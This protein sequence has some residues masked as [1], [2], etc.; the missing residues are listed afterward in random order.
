[1]KKITCLFICFLLCFSCFP[2]AFAEKASTWEAEF[3]RIMQKTPLTKST[4]FVL[5]DVDADNVPELIAGNSQT[6]SLY[7]FSNNSLVRT[8]EV[9]DIHIDY[10]AQLK[11]VQKGNAS[12]EFVGQVV[13]SDRITSYKMRFIDGVPQLKTI[14]TENQDAT[15]SFYGDNDTS[16]IVPD[17]TA[18]VIDYFSKYSLTPST[19]CVLSREEARSFGSILNAATS[20]CARYN[21]LASLSDDTADFSADERNA[22]KDAVGKG[23]F[24]FFDKIS[25]LSSADIFV[26]FYVSTP[27]NDGN[28]LL[29]YAKQFALLTKTE[30]GFSTSST[31]TH[32]NK[33]DITHL[34]SLISAEN[35]VSNISFDYKRTSAF[36]GIDDYVNYLSSTLSAASEDANENGKYAISEYIEHA[37]TRSSR[38]EIKAKN[39]TISLN[40]YSVS[41][42]AEN[43]VHCLA[44]LNTVCDSNGITLNR[45]ARA[46]PELVCKGLDFDRPVRIEFEP[47]LSQNLLGASGFRLMLDETHGISI[48]AADLAALEKTYH[49]F[50]IEFTHRESAFSVVFADQNNEPLT[51]IVAP[52]GFVVPAKNLYSTVM[53]SFSGGTANWGGQFDMNNKTL[54]FSTNYSGDYEIVEND[55]TINDIADLETQTQNAIRFLVSKGVFTLDQK[56]NFY[57]DKKLNRYDFTAALVKM[58]YAL[59]YDAQSSFRDISPDSEMYHYIASAESLGIASGFSDSTFRGNDPVSKE[60]VVTLCGRTLAEKKEYEY[61]KSY[62]QYLNFDDNGDIS[63]WARGDIAIAAQCGLVENSGLFS[64][65]S[66]VSRS[67]GA[68]ILYKTFMLLY[69][70]SPVTTVSSIEAEDE[71]VPPE[72]NAQIDV[73]FRAAMCILISVLV[74]FCGYI[75]I[76]IRRRLKKRK[77]NNA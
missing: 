27:Q 55:I 38:T 39:N 4:K 2:T 74:L 62:G 14:A 41:F 71:K 1:M 12:P 60:Q 76:K 75:A 24:A 65:K 68:Q 13:F 49:T 22:I 54:A 36:R 20:F 72:D 28:R 15:G 37:V 31:Y 35:Q 69:D 57:P 30:K 73:E 32:E 45:K 6:V 67:E 50:C 59:N 64:P 11:T 61:P 56:Q 16:Q 53:V 70:V 25:R 52:V 47:E 48:T 58:F 40:A 23:K 17:C 8:A 63:E 19:I 9:N 10:F 18:Q 33:L 3:I 44:R 46:L 26:Q 7:S 5:L 66:A 77:T 34:S 29:S 51:Y 21:F 42:I 43:A